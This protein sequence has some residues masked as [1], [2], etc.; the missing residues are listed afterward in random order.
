MNELNTAIVV[1]NKPQTITE[2]RIGFSLHISINDIIR[3]SEK[4]LFCEAFIQQIYQI[5]INIEVCM[6]I[7]NKIL[8]SSAYNLYPKGA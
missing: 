6:E 5:Y 7:S 8:K 4:M 3:L 1:S 2:T